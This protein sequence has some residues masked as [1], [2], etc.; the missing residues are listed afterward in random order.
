MLTEF[1]DQPPCPHSKNLNLNPRQLW[2]SR[3]WT[4]SEEFVLGAWNRESKGKRNINDIYTLHSPAIVWWH[5]AIFSEIDAH[6]YRGWSH[7]L[8]SICYTVAMEYP[9]VWIHR[10]DRILCGNWEPGFCSDHSIRI[11]VYQ[12][13]TQLRQLAHN[14]YC[15]RGRRI[16]EFPWKIRWNLP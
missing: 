6:I 5:R 4:P 13:N 7:C 3:S 1:K 8:P 10:R 14:G 16:P 2:L 12:Q 15:V 11:C 9:A